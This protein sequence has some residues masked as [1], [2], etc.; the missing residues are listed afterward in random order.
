MIIKT[1]ILILILEYQ[2]CYVYHHSRSAVH[3]NAAI[4]DHTLLS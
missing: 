2:R 1:L 4:F 3:R